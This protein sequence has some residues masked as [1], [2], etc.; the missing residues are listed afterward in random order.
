[1]ITMK[2]T[3]IDNFLKKAFR[4]LDLGDYN[5]ITMRNDFRSGFADE[6]RDS[7][8]GTPLEEEFEAIVEELRMEDDLR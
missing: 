7:F 1:M 3:K 5:K 8:K 2:K 4:I 6:W